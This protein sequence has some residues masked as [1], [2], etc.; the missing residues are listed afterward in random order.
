[1]QKAH[2]YKYHAF[3]LLVAGAM[4]FF[5][6][7]A[8]AAT[9]G[10]VSGTVK[11]ASGQPVVGAQVRIVSTGETTKTDGTGAFS[12]GGED[13]GTITIEVSSAALQTEKLTT[14]IA[15]DINQRLD[16]VLQRRVLGGTTTFTVPLINPTQT[17]TATL[18]TA[19]EE[20]KV[21][22][23]PNNL[24]QFPGLLFGQPGITYDPGGYVHIRGS[25]LFQVGFQFDGISILDPIT[26]EFGTNLVTVG[27]KSAN[28]YT[29]GADASYGDATGGF[30][31]EISSSGRDLH[32]RGL[33]GITELT[34]G[35]GSN[36]NYL[37][38]NTQ[39][40]NVTK[41]GKFDYYLSTIRFRNTFPAGF[42]VTNLPDSQDTA[43]KFNYYPDANNT[44]TA[45]YAHGLEDY[46]RGAFGALKIQAPSFNAAV[47]S[48]P[49]GEEDHDVQHYDMG[50]VALRHKFSA[51]S[52]INYRFYS[53][54]STLDRH[55]LQVA[56]Q[57]RKN[58]DT[59]Q[60]HQ[61]DY[62]N[63][64]T[65][66]FRLTGGVY[67]LPATTNYHV[68]TG[69]T[70][71]YNSP[72]FAARGYTDRSSLIN[73][74]ETVLYLQGQFKPSGDK[75]TLDIGARYAARGYRNIKKYAPFTD[76]Y[77]DPRLGLAF[78][79]NHDLQ[80][81]TSFSRFSQF[82][83]TRYNV[84][85]SPQ[86]TAGVFPT[87]ATDAGKQQARIDFRYPLQRLKPYYSENLDLGVAKGFKAYGDRYA[88]GLTA[89]SKKQYSLLT[90][91]Q[92]NYGSNGSAFPIVYDNS[93]R[94]QATGAE[95]TFQKEARNEYDINGFVTYTNQVARA[96]SSAFDTGYAPY[97][98]TFVSD[99]TLTNAQFRSFN[100]QEFSPSYDQRHTVAV[101]VSKK[102]SHLF[103]TSIVL[104]AGSGFP[105]NRG[106]AS[107]GLNGGVDGQHG[108]KLVGTN[109]DFTEVPVFLNGQT[110]SPLS[111]VVG[112]SS[113]HY[114]FSLNSDFF[115][116][117]DTS[118]FVNV[119][120]IFDRLTATIISTTDAN[121]NIYYNAPTAAQPQ[122]S[123][124]YGAGAGSITP[125]FLSFGFRHKF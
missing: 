113:W 5:P 88:V 62:Q 60:G 31:N 20:Q 123:I 90:L 24:Y 47:N 89:F 6:L 9:T 78:A 26:N 32:A 80:F 23:Q 106:T 66:K 42:G 30:I 99:P 43:V 96:T 52:F 22:S 21:K 53:L 83:E 67:Y 72:G 8:H 84:Y 122:G 120:N 1:M 37:G 56:N 54:F 14:T 11:N 34:V 46:H 97:F 68:L 92:T 118:L 10:T 64:F 17:A 41:D 116:S 114:K 75:L 28:F 59:T 101:V 87:T 40:G 48:D 103:G 18:I 69:V 49:N 112:H 104:D 105:Y 115:V 13:P 38:T 119:D 93:G 94:G 51:K 77:L 124:H 35:P 125:I 98:S 29:N 117:K 19:G 65:P 4:S 95:F 74:A 121:G 2:F 70:A 102:F 100:Q 79:P 71:P 33:N 7:T 82:P 12:F 109:G 76:Q 73:L 50:Y 81:H 110:L 111:P 63:Q 27:L 91:N 108:E 61:I 16:F 15:Q 3:P 58:S 39:L 45:F 25:D 85:L 57:Y 86:E 107:D 44:V 55:L 36:W